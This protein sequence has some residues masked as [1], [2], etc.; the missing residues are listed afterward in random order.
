MIYP[1]VDSVPRF[2]SE[3]YEAFLEGLVLFT[4]MWFAGRRPALRARF[5]FLTGLFLLG[6][7]LARFTAEFAREPDVFLG[8]LAFGLSMGQILSLPMVAIGLVFMLAARPRAVAE[9]ASQ[10]SLTA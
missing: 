3:L 7:G 10:P 1:R 9:P 6:Y 5:G 2:P 4:V 8:F